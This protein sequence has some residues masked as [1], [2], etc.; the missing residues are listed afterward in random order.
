MIGFYLLIVCV[1]INLYFYSR[2]LPLAFYK[3]SDKPQKG[4]PASLIVCAKNE[5]EQLEKHIPLWLEQQHPDFE[6]ILINDR[7]SDETLKVMES[8]AVKDK[9]ISIVNVR[10]NETFWANKKYALTLGIKRA[11]HPRL[12]FTDADCRPASKQWLGAMSAQLDQKQELVLG[13]GPYENRPGFLNRLIRYE[14]AMTGVQYLSAALRG[15]AYMGVGRNLA[16]T[17]SLFFKQSGFMSHM[18]LASGDDDLFVNQASTSDNTN[19]CLNVKA[20]TYSIPK[21]NLA[22][23]IRQKRRHIT[24][25]TNYSL[26]QRISLTLYFLSNW[27]FWPLVVLGFILLPWWW[28]AP[29]ALVRIIAQYAVTGLSFKQLNEKGLLA[30]TPLLELV[31]VWLQLIIF[32]SNLMAKPKHWK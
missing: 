12:I 27:A 2:F 23:W 25:A 31:L 3:G 17:S 14:T 6:L 29:L 1:L 13:Y 32:I 26:G 16:Y 5:A 9:R 18:N 15:K 24:T 21:D 20:F 30:L 22:E 8:W 4:F 10:E 7:S 28:I 19:V 11:T